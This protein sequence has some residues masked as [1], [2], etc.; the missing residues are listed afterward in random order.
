MRRS[1]FTEAQI[2]DVVREYDAGVSPKELTRRHGIHVNTIW[3]TWTSVLSY[4]PLCTKKSEL[5]L[6]G[7]VYSFQRKI[8]RD[9]R[10]SSKTFSCI[11]WAHRCLISSL[12]ASREVERQPCCENS[13]R[14]IRELR[15]RS[16]NARSYG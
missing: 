11:P 2:V 1:K 16:A 15:M 8:P 13:S 5:T 7:D 3:G 4:W 10:E 6:F 12:W 14:V 9:L